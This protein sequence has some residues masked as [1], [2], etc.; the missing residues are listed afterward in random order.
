MSGEH[1]EQ[2][3]INWIC[4]PMLEQQALTHL[5]QIQRFWLDGGWD[6]NSFFL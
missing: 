1:E 5:K 6:N 2:Q 3:T 4:K